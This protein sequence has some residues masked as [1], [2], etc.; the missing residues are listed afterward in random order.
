MFAR[1]TDRSRSASAKFWSLLLSV[2][3]EGIDQ[4]R[5][6]VPHV[7]AALGDGVEG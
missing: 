1:S 4:L 5:E 6:Q 2:D 3:A 7:L